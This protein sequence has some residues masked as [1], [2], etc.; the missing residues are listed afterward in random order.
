VI[1]GKERDLVP[2]FANGDPDGNKNLCTLGGVKSKIQL[3]TRNSLPALPS[4]TKSNS[5]NQIAT[6][7]SIKKYPTAKT[8]KTP[9]PRHEYAG[10]AFVN[11]PSPD[12]VPQPSFLNE[13]ELEKSDSTS[14][15]ARTLVFEEPSIPFTSSPRSFSTIPNV[16]THQSAANAQQFPIFH[17]ITA[18][19]PVP[20]TNNI[21][22]H[23]HVHELS[24]PTAHLKRLLNITVA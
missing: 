13:A 1:L 14:D 4:P 12:L 21:L 8:L 19:R 3:K 9:E 22:R 11:S 23:P 2:Y 15:V 20:A 16:T 5:T 7:K 10:E 18:H 17:M 6:P 24:D